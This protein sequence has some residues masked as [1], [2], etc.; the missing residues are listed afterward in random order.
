MATES[1]LLNI[2]RGQN[3]RISKLEER[4]EEALFQIEKLVQADVTPMDEIYPDPLSLSLPDPHMTTT[5]TLDD[6]TVSTETPSPCK[7]IALHCALALRNFFAMKKPDSLIPETPE[8]E[9]NQFEET[10]L[11]TST[12]QDR[13]E[14]DNQDNTTLQSIDGYV[15]TFYSQPVMSSMNVEINELKT[16]QKKLLKHFQNCNDSRDRR[17]LVVSN[18]GLEAWAEYLYKKNMDN[19]PFIKKQLMGRGLDFLLTDC[20]D[21][22]LSKTGTL[23]VIFENITE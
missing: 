23:Y 17:T 13:A 3:I 4:L 21:V 19:W 6:S 18:I 20:V 14:E 22:R 9:D 7:T 8:Y 1:E 2:I 16:N 5:T 10:V 11:S 15:T 12:S